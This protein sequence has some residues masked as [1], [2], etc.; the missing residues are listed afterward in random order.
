MS[1][2]WGVGPEGEDKEGFVRSARA[3]AVAVAFREWVAFLIRQLINTGEMRLPWLVLQNKQGIQED[4][5]GL[6]V[7]IRRKTKET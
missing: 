6:R 1:Q 2:S 7:E 3:G 4:A 5:T